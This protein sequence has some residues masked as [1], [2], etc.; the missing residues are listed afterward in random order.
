MKDRCVY[1]GFSPDEEYMQDLYIKDARP[2]VQTVQYGKRLIKAL[3]Y[4]FDVSNIST[5]PIQD[6]PFCQRIFIFKLNWNRSGF[7]PFVNI[8]GFKQVFRFIF[9]LFFLIKE[10]VVKNTKVVVVHGVHLPF[11]VSTYLASFLG[12]KTI[13]VATDP[14]GV[15]L[16][17]DN[18]IRR[19]LK[20]IDRILID[21]FMSKFDA[22]VVPSDDYVQDFGFKDNI[23]YF[24]IPGIVDFESG[25][26]SYSVN[27]LEDSIYSF[28]KNKKHIGYSG[29]VY[30]NNGLDVLVDSVTHFDDGMILHIIGNGEYLDSLRV[31][32]GSNKKIIFHGFKT[33][34]E[35]NY[36]MDNMDVL[37]NVRPVDMEFT[38]Y[39]FPS[40]LFE[41]I[42]RDKVVVSS[43]LKTIPQ[44]IEGCF[45]YFEKLESNYISNK[46]IEICSNL[47]NFKNIK[48]KELVM[49]YFS[50]DAV[51][52]KFSNLMSK[53]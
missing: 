15:P 2:S 29:S 43:K 8:L 36:L 30:E 21:F 17:S 27:G 32:A 51:S 44:E 33:G 46:L 50:L 47:E 18:Y 35:F 42:L 6:Y 13:L 28:D 53:L 31:R 41:Y 25:Y 3:G 9:S 10:V 34:E 1:L 7:I 4:N 16:S 11:L 20:I 52:K 40:K 45:E 38:K 22:A 14:P 19:N 39:S 26:F 5:P 23:P 24:V 49:Q 37:I 48:N 12:L